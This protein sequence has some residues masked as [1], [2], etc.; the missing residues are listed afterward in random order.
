MTEPP[1]ASKPPTESEAVQAL[2][3]ALFELLPDSARRIGY[4][5]RFMG[6][7]VEFDVALADRDGRIV[8]AEGS[9]TRLSRAT[10]RT[11]P[12]GSRRS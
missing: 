9:F 8:D 7:D 11:C 10:L 4:E 3:A 5:A 6:H 12:T 1:T 2:G